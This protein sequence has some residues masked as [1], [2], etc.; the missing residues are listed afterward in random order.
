MIKINQF[1]PTVG[2][3][4]KSDGFAQILREAYEYFQENNIQMISGFSEIL[5]EDGLFNEYVARLT[6]GCS[7]DE[8]EQLEQLFENSRLHTLQ[9]STISQISPLAGLSMPTVR[10]MWIKCALKN[11]VP[12]ETAKVPSFT[13]SWL[14]PYLR[15][16]D[17]TKHPLPE[18]IQGTGFSTLAQKPPLFA[19]NIPVPADNVDMLALSG[20]SQANH[21]AIDPILSITTARINVA[22]AGATP[23]I[24]SVPVTFKLGIAAGNPITS[25]F[26]GVVNTYDANNNVISD[27]IFGNIDLETGL[28][29]VASVKSL[30]TG[31]SMTGWLTQENNTRTQSVSFDIKRKDVRIGTGTHL[32]APLPIEWLQD[33]LALYNID[34]TVET[35]DIMSNVVAQKLDHDI[36]DFFQNSFKASGSPL[37]GRFDV[38]P[39]AGFAGSPTDWRH[40]LRTTVEWWA[41]K[42]KQ[43]TN[44]TQGYFVIFGNPLDINLMPDIDWQFK[45]VQGER[46]GV[47]VNYDFGV[48]TANNVYS[49]VAS[50][51]VPQ[52]RLSMFFVP[53]VD[54]YMTYKY[55]PY[56]FNVEKGYLDPQMPNVPSI[57][58]TKRQALEE[59]IPMQCQIEILH[60]DGSLITSYKL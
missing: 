1:K 24:Q 25:G 28:L 58:M 42:L 36:R 34:G 23:V 16:S 50:N 60:N 49:I 31:V 57:M 10:K 46:A 40:E 55:Y 33:N 35:V 48:M 14:E 37:I 20:A 27:T 17:G 19:G 29:S 26:Y 59:L 15:D 43:A 21:D 7:P 30:V 38:R 3:K 9:E 13:I 4:G 8:A 18:S 51:N 53:N 45:N 44:F 2:K 54:N 41:T 5:G 32:N 6:E 56:T 22:A 47:N 39:S 11:A 12:T 52:G